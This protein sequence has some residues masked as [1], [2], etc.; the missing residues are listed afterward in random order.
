MEMLANRP[1]QT[2]GA[3]V[4]VIPIGDTVAEVLKS[5]ALLRANGI[6]TSMDTSG[7]KLKK[8][9]AAA[10]SRGIRYVML[11]GEN[12]ASLGQVRLKDMTG[13]TETVLTLDEAI[14]SISDQTDLS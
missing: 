8:S 7:R 11:I 10:S 6:R 9:L 3:I 4:T 2:K 12:E 13:M 14:T 5:A 1:V